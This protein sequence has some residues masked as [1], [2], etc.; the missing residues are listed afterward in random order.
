ME[1]SAN[2]E[3]EKL[4]QQ[5]AQ[6]GK[7]LE[8]LNNSKE[9][10]YKEKTSFDSFLSNTIAEANELK[11]KKKITDEEIKNKKLLRTTLNKELKELSIKIKSLQKPAASTKLKK[12]LSPDAAKK[13]IEAMQYAIE[14]EGLSFEKEKQYMDRINQ[15]KAEL[16]ESP[17]EAAGA[18]KELRETLITKK[19]RADLIHVEIQKLAEDSTKDFD[20]LTAKAKAIIEAK[21]KRLEIQGKLKEI[22]LQIEAKNQDLAE[23]LN[24]WLLVTK[25]LPTPVSAEMSE[26]DVINKF[27][28]S[29]KLTKD[30]ILKLQRLATR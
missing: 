12:R 25:D 22:K 13:Q 16:A 1:L 3:I 23:S 15:L 10:W 18:P 8:S 11:T 28:N 6:L 21:N 19:S 17:L 27:K 4:R 30:D 14:T 24:Q 20:Q 5:I 2:A 7:D 26:A 29:K 9:S